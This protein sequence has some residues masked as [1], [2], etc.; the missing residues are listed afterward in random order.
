[1]GR[2]RVTAVVARLVLLCGLPGAG[3]T[4]LALRLERELPALRLC[5]D[6]WMTALG[7]DLFDDAARDVVEG[8]QWHL[9]RRVLELGGTVILENGFWGRAEREERRAVARALGAR[10][11]LRFLDAPLDE[12]WRRIER[13][14]RQ[15]GWGAAPITRDQLEQWAPHFEPPDEA[16]LALYD[17]PD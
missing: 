5:P 11:E 6:D 17:A 8:L 10:V 15:P 9:A 12:L 16:E 1:M 3:K 7:H 2:L 4:T 14:N 13:R